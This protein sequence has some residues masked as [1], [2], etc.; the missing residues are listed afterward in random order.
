MKSK[1]TLSYLMLLGLT[2]AP[3]AILAN[4]TSSQE[5]S[6]Q[7]KSAKVRTV[8]GCLAKGGSDNEYTLTTDSGATW[9]LKS[10]SVQIAP[11]VGHKVSVT[12]TVD[13]AALHGAKEKAKEK[14]EDNPKE[15]GHMTVTNLEMVSESCGR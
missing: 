13:N 4:Q 14:T 6:T 2:I 7:D 3:P 11:H 15:H 5:S 9:E 8:T 1:L 12:G 10:D